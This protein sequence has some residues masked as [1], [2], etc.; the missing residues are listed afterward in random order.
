MVATVLTDLVQVLNP[1][2]QRQGYKEWAKIAP[3]LAALIAPITSLLD[4]PALTVSQYR[5]LCVV[6]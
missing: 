5:R 4:I 2:Q 1:S 3:L 6:L